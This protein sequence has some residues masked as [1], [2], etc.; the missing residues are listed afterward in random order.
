MVKGFIETAI[1]LADKDDWLEHL[2]VFEVHDA[3]MMCNMECDATVRITVPIDMFLRRHF[4]VDRNGCLCVTEAE[5]DINPKR[6]QHRPVD[7]MDGR[8]LTGVAELLNVIASAVNAYCR[9]R[10]IRVIQTELAALSGGDVIDL[11]EKG[12]VQTKGAQQ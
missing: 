12:N 5:H 2:E 8:G 6:R 3:Q 10:I 11:D 9:A 1:G 7:E 4:C